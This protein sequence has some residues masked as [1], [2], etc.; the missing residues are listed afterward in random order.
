MTTLS[1]AV[2]ALR[3]S[4]GRGYDLDAPRVRAALDAGVPGFI[5]FGGSADAAGSAARELT[6]R[7]GRPLLLGADLERGAG[8]QFRGAT[9]L[10][11]LSAL[12]ALGDMRALWEAGAL[13]GREAVSLGIPW[14]FAPVADLAL[15]PENPIV[16]TR[17]LGDDPGRVAA[18][19][20]AWVQGCLSAGG[21]PCVK[22]FPG[23]GRTVEDSHAV[24]PVVGESAHDLRDGDLVPFARAVSAG[25]PSVMTAHVSYPSL[26][27]SGAPATRSRAMVEGLLRG[28]MGFGGVVV[29]DALIMEGAG[30]AASAVVEA[31]AAGVDLLLY[32]PDDV[33]VEDLRREALA[34]GRLDA[35]AAGASARRVEALLRR[36][37]QPLP[38][39]RWG[40]PEDLR[41]ARDLARRVLAWSGGPSP[42]GGEL[43]VTVV[44]DDVGGPYPPP[45]RGP[46]LSALR[47]RGVAMTESAPH[48]LLCLYAEPRA[49]K[50]RAGLSPAARE[51]VLRWAAADGTATGDGPGRM[52]AVFGGPR[53]AAEIPEG[54]PT[55][56]AWGGESLMQEA[57]AAWIADRGR[58]AGS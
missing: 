30:E 40:A 34:S 44:D 12:G 42:G 56:V 32:P 52:V 14:I 36:V 3:W 5:L 20:E 31:L 26:D 24:L 21:I 7:S 47:D 16:A 38:P 54:I 58:E 19:V 55:L 17:A 1:P 4:D 13:T 27:P 48:R 43:A 15:E 35:E 29:T 28:E 41:W 6:R 10:P 45:S 33:P 49:W 57:A 39:S 22:H 8:Q 25:V 18:Q 23:H 2:P 51:A 53:V 46:F 37:P 11:P 9:P 50:G